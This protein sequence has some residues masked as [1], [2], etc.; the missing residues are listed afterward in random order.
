MRRI[1]SSKVACWDC[2]LKVH[3]GRSVGN[4][5]RWVEM[6]IPGLGKTEGR[7]GWRGVV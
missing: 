4:R 2:V 7:A 6:L 5:Y 3:P 1:L